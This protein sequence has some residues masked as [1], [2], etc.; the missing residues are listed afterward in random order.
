LGVL[1]QWIALWGC[2]ERLVERRCERRGGCVKIKV[3]SIEEE[4]G[5]R[6]SQDVF[7]GGAMRFKDAETYIKIW[8]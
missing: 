6:K 5:D 3:A 4:P 1:K 8:E 2:K 7:L